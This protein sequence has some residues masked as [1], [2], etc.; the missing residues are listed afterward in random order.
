VQISGPVTAVAGSTISYTAALTNSGPNTATN[1]HLTG[2]LPAGLMLMQAGTS[3]GTCATTSVSFDC[4][5]GSVAAGVSANMTL[6]VRSNQTGLIT[7]T[8]QAT[9]DTPDPNPTNNSD[10][11]TTNWTP[12]ADLALQMSGPVAAIGGALVSYI[13]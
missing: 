1:I 4:S 7:T 3:Q 10:S 9:S 5:V 13:P 6:Q 2:T 12:N 8:V 11:A